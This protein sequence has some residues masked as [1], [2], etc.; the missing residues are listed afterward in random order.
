VPSI[1]LEPW[2]LAQFRER[3]ARS[4]VYGRID[5]PPAIEVRGPVAAR[6]YSIVDRARYLAGQE[7]HGSQLIIP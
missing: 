6:L 2:E 5:W 3:F 7:I 4:N 1:L